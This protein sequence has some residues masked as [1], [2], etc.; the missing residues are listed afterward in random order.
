[1]A[2]GEP[3]T[4]K[5]IAAT[6]HFTEPP[7]R[8]SEASLVKRMEELGIGRP[9]TYASI[10]QVLQ[11]RSYVRIE[12]KR[13]VPED[14]GRIVVAFLESFFARYVEYDFTADLEEQLDLV[15][16][17]E[18]EWH[19]LLR[20]FWQGFTAAVDEIK[21]LRIGQVIEA[22]DEMLAPHIFPPR[23]DGTDPRL[24][25][26]CGNGRLS[27][28][29]GKFG[30]FIG[31][32]NYPECR[33][34]RPFSAAAADGAEDT[35][36]RVLGI[37]PDSGLEVSLRAGRFGPYVQLGAGAEGE[38]PKRAGLPRGT[39]AAAVDLEMALKLLSLPREVGPHPEDGE[40]IRAGIGRFGAY[41][42]HGKT[43]ANLEPGDDVLNI[44]LNRAVALIADKVAKG[45]RA[46]FGAD[47]GRSLGDHP[48]KG[49]A[50]LVKAGRYGPYVSHDG[51]MRRSRRTSRR[52]RSRWTRRWCCSRLAPH[53]AARGAVP[54]AAR[55]PN[56]PAG[57]RRRR[58]PARPRPR[59]MARRMPRKPK[60]RHC[61]L[62]PRRRNRQ[63]PARPESRPPPPNQRTSRLP[64][65]NRPQESR[66][67]PA[68][69]KPG[70]DAAPE[71]H[72]SHSLT[73]CTLKF[74]L[75]KSTNR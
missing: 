52:K 3:L 21:D 65:Q 55:R 43:Y 54:G 12:K 10:L 74:R 69:P 50:V 60:A 59:T 14:R 29:L 39:E 18:L 1:M 34:T 9:S 31:C 15:S 8:Y 48:E 23:P 11:D 19:D 64:Q 27:L 35:G 57:R 40:P 56:R 63:P 53:R 22:L 49:G 20:K 45:P 66:P 4:K 7:P 68:A 72:G 70:S 67:L 2:A 62:S 38:K 17:N 51:S 73:I 26:V 41:V 42:Q 46:R 5:A 24:C 33:N 6:Q 44:G 25:T 75:V 47:P 16:N 58:R 32:S 36:T 30:A 71:A 13:L 61:P 28:K 37:D